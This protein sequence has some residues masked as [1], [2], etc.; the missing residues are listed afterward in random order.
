MTPDPSKPVDWYLMTG[1]FF[2]L[3][4]GAFTL[5]GDHACFIS[6]PKNDAQ[7][8]IGVPTLVAYHFTH[9]R[10]VAAMCAFVFWWVLFGLLSFFV[11]NVLIRKVILPNQ[12]RSMVQAERV[13]TMLK[14]KFRDEIP[15]QDH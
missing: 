9:E 14:N 3:V 11:L 15:E 7:L 1:I 10:P 2:V 5:Q 6:P 8:L 4:A 12:V 13:Q